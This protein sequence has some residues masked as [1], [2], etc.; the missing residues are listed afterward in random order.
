MLEGTEL[1]HTFVLANASDAPLIVQSAKSDCACTVSTPVLRSGSGVT[2]E[3][4]YGQS[5]AP[6]HELE[7]RVTLD[8]KGKRDSTEGNLVVVF[9]G[10]QEPLKLVVSAE[11][12]PSFL[13]T[14]TPLDLGSFTTS[15]VRAGVVRL[16]S[17]AGG[18]FR[19]SLGEASLPQ[20]LNATLSAE[21]EDEGGFAGAWNLSVTLGP[22]A[23]K[24]DNHYYSIPLQCEWRESTRA[25]ADIRE[26]W[27]KDPKVSV[28]AKVTGEVEVEPG[29]LSLGEIP[30]G[31]EKAATV[32][33]FAARAASLGVDP[34]ACRISESDGLPEGNIQLG[35]KRTS[36]S[37]FELTATV[38]TRGGALGPFRA[39]IVV[40]TGLGDDLEIPLFGI[41]KA[42]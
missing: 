11:V 27:S 34:A 17:P 3:F 10:T 40:P 37:A 15:E 39:T 42:P 23:P 22:D 32:S 2:S 35:L 12:I 5:V 31:E 13:A 14:P 25:S 8:T 16:T 26:R 21:V 41:L 30:I 28:I 18:S 33:V 20:E 1:K 9:E 29:Y 19:L 4:V 6:D 24:F 7:L 36:A 38:Q